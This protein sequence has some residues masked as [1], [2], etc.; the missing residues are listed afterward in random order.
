MEACWLIALIAVPLLVNPFG[1]FASSLYK[2]ALLRTLVG[3][4]IALWLTAGI[5]LIFTQEIWRQRV[6]W[7]H[8]LKGF[9]KTPLMAPVLALAGVYVLSTWFSISPSTSLWGSASRTQ[10]AYTTLALLGFFLI[11]AWQMRTVAQI[12]RVIWAI[13]VAGS[14]VSLLGIAEWLGWSPWLLERSYGTWRISATTGHPTIL[15][16]Y[17]VLTM[18]LLLGK[19][20]HLWTSIREQPDRKIT[21]KLGGF[22]VLALIQLTALLLTNARGPWLGFVAMITVFAAALLI[23]NHHWRMLRL[24]TLILVL[25]VVFQIGLSQPRSVFHGLSD[26]PYLSRVAEISD[27]ESGSGRERVVIWDATKD[28][29]IKRPPVAPTG[30]PGNWVRPLLGY[31]PETLALAFPSVFPPEMR[32]L[33]PETQ[34]D[35]AHNVVLDLMVTVG[36]LGVLAFG[37]VLGTFFF[38]AGRLL[39]HTQRRAEQYLLVALI[40]AA[41]G[42]LVT[43]LVGISDLADGLVFWTLLALLV[44]LARG[45]ARVEHA[46]SYE[47]ASFAVGNKPR[48]L[49][50]KQAL[51]GFMALAVA[52][53]MLG[54]SLYSNANLVWAD[55]QTR[56]GVDHMK[57][58]RWKEAASSFER[59]L[60]S[61][62]LRAFNYW[63]LAQVNS[64]QAL[65]SPDPSEQ[66]R[67]LGLAS[68]RIEKAR[69]LEPAEAGYHQRAGLIYSYWALTLDPAKYDEAAQAFAQAA[70]LSPNEVNIYNQWA[71]LEARSHNYEKALELL[72]QSLD[73]DP[74]WAPTQYQLASVYVSFG[75]PA[76]ARPYA[77]RYVQAQPT[78]WEGRLLLAKVYQGLGMTSAAL[79]QGTLALSLAPAPFQE[80][81]RQLM[82]SLR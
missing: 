65:E 79:E 78:T 45:A 12:N 22:G 19:L 3:V 44:S 46:Q 54:F 73:V 43:Q 6:Q 64:F 16:A 52:M 29:I 38:R 30:D 50:R 36:L 25:G 13:V 18:A 27:V 4:M 34:V 76:Q 11:V 51:L 66:A 5:S 26:L 20:A 35:R 69:A 39:K 80:Q 47:Q 49:V 68:T 60:N 82:D 58:A 17:L 74:A 42:Y 15:G 1:G 59:A 23:R 40:A 14:L 28:L 70:A 21:L 8:G 61:P 24:L 37:W 10:G 77:E 48:A 2:V 41:A 75:K 67:L 62:S 55:M 53:S 32:H 33:E 63:H 56:K 71:D 7:Y 31:G 81:V 72:H 9:L 57:H